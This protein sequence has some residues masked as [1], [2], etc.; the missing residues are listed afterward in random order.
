[1]T[2]ADVVAIYTMLQEAGIAIW[3]DGGWAVDALLE[4]QTRPHADLDVV[5][6]SRLEPALR[7]L[8]AAAGFADRPRDDT[9]PWNFVLADSSGREVDVHVIT[10]DEH[11]AGIYGP[12]ER[13]EA[14]RAGSLTGTGRI[15]G[16]RVACV[17]AS[18][19]VDFHRGYEPDDD[20]Y[21]DVTLLCARFGLPLPEEYRRPFPSTP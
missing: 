12:P 6:E 10:F 11:G 18:S 7:R 14:Y 8:L 4:R 3:I 2:G 9:R 5:V 21:R 19:L 13:G 15:A 1:M 16:V 17:A 20:D